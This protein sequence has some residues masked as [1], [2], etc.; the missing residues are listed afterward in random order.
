MM[1]ETCLVSRRRK[2]GEL[3]LNA[4]V[5]IARPTLVVTTTT[6]WP[7]A[8][9]SGACRLI[10][11]GLTIERYAALPLIVTLV[12]PRVVGKSAFQTAVPLARFV[13]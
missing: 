8:V 7:V 6:T 13:P 5:V 9:S 12:L 3:G 10:C 2:D 1:A 4:T 11:P